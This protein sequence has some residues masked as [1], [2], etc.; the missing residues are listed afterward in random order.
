MSILLTFVFCLWFVYLLN[1][2]RRKWK[3][4]KNE[5]RCLKQGT[6]GVQQ[7]TLAYNAKTELVK[8]IMLFFLNLI[9]W[10][11]FII[12]RM[13]YMIYFAEKLLHHSQSRDLNADPFPTTI[14]N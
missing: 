9:E 1:T 7:Q 13:G 14:L 4:Y 12:A 5:L 10:I 3:F 11:A 8:N 6:N 2:I